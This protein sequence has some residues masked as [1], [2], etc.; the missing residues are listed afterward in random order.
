MKL[1]DAVAE[2]LATQVKHVFCVS[3]GANLH[4][5]DSIA[6]RHDIQLVCT[7]T[8]AAAGFA[9]GLAAFL[10]AAFAF[11]AAF[12]GAAFLAVAFLAA[13]FVAIISPCCRRAL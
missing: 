8:E 12:L 13:F 1:S 10:G 11:L 5:I 9:A 2:Y 4:A 6:K 7:Q 3:G